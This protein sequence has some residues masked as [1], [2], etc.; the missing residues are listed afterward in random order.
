MSQGIERLVGR[1]A[2]LGLVGR[3]QITELLDP[4]RLGKRDGP[5][6]REA[7][8]RS[9]ARHR[10]IAAFRR[11]AGVSGSRFDACEVIAAVPG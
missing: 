6:A 8:P 2:A 10:I 4:L 3:P 9:P 5:C 1:A 11:Q 7:A